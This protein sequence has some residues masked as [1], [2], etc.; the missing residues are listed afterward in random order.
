VTLEA[1]P[2]LA[3][4]PEVVEELERLLEEARRGQIRGLLAV[5]AE[6][7]FSTGRSLALGDGAVVALLG[8][9]RIAEQRLLDEIRATNQG[10]L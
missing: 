1:L 9:L 4:V 5:T 10:K 3:P 8:E 2:E 6:L 7:G